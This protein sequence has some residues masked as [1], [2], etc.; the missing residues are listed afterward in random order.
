M[1]GRVELARVMHSS[2]DS[3]TV[4]SIYSFDRSPG[5]IRVLIAGHGPQMLRSGVSI[6]NNNVS[7]EKATLMQICCSD[8]MAL[9]C[10]LRLVAGSRHRHYAPFLACLFFFYSSG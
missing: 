10:K 2:V 9:V 1:F 5:A 4:T 6:S 8:G 3:L 7:S